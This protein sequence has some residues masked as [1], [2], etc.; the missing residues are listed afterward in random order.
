MPKFWR[1]LRIFRRNHGNVPWSVGSKF[2]C[3]LQN[4]INASVDLLIRVVAM[5]EKPLWKGNGHFFSSIFFQILLLFWV[6]SLLLIFLTDNFST[7]LIPLRKI[8]KLPSS[9]LL[10]FFEGKFYFTPS[11]HFFGQSHDL[12]LWSFFFIRIQNWLNAH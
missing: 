1:V 3:K 2:R 10:L 9:P 7:V 8:K 6:Y 11:H 4:F 12:Q 5:N